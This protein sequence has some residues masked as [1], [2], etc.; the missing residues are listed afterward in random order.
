VIA[1]I[2][3]TNGPAALPVPID[4]VSRSGDFEGGAGHGEFQLTR[5][6]F[7]IERIYRQQI[8]KYSS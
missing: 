5:I 4:G 1:V 6:K 3:D 2:P 8:E 7:H